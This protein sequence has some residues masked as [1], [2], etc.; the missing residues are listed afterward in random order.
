MAGWQYGPAAVLRGRV[1]PGMKSP[2]YM[3]NLPGV[4]HSKMLLGGAYLISS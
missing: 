3:C 1:T 2:L 4:L